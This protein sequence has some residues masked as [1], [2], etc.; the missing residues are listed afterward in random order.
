MDKLL[1]IETEIKKP[2]RMEAIK[3]EQRT[4]KESDMPSQRP[5]LSQM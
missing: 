2:Q 5:S 4:C 1:T 3:K